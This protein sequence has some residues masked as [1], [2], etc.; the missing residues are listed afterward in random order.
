MIYNVKM[1]LSQSLSRLKIKAKSKSKS[2]SK[3]PIC[4][5][6]KPLISKPVPK[7]KRDL[8][9]GPDSELN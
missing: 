2:K 7:S 1:M 8:S 4:L 6:R 9:H 5:F 3:S